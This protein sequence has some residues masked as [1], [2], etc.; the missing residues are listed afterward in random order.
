MKNLM[1]T[2]L[3]AATLALS[4]CDTTMMNND[5]LGGAAVGGV[6]GAITATALGADTDWLIIGTLAGAAAGALVA[7]NQ[8]TGDCAYSDGRGGYYR[9]RCR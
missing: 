5:Q 1:I 9:A 2:G 8:A 3:C 4:A 6:L 7:Q